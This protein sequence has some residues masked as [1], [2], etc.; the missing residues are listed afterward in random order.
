[1][2]RA[3]LI[4][5]HCH[6]DFETFA[7]EID[8]VV[9]RAHQADVSHMVTIS[10]RIKRL[11]DIRAI[12]RCRV[13]HICRDRLE[14]TAAHNVKIRIRQPHIDDD[15]GDDNGNDNEMNDAEN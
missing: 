13:Y 15:N 7:N 9:A 12:H 3:T 11:P 8:D 2:T 10:T 4:D 1:M 14:G 6:L 5:S